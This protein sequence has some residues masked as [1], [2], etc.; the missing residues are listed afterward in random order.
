MKNKEKRDVVGA[1]VIDNRGRILLQKKTVD[2]IAVPGGGWCLFGGEIESGED[3]KKT[4]KRELKEELGVDFDD[5]R[6]FSNHHYQLDSGFWGEEYT[7]IV[8]F[9]GKISDIRLSEGAGFAFFDFSELGSINLMD[10]AKDIIDRYLAS[11]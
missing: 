5:I 7:F 6:F 2:Y 1:I 8:K 11:V 10:M 4:L 9:N 3:P